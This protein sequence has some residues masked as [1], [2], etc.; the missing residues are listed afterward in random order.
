MSAGSMGIFPDNFNFDGKKVKFIHYDGTP[1]T[2]L[3]GSRGEDKDGNLV[4][5]E[6][7]DV[8][9]PILNGKKLFKRL[10][11]KRVFPVV[12]IEEKTE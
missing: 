9:A 8:C 6:L 3:V 2:H 11:I 10:I 12:E 4:F 1:A 5:F 7:I